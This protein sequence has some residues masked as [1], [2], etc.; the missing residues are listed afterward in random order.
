MIDTTYIKNIYPWSSSVTDDQLDFF[1]AEAYQ[2]H[3][4]ATYQDYQDQIISLYLAHKAYLEVQNNLAVG[5]ALTSIRSEKTVHGMINF[6]SGKSYWE[7]S[8][9][10]KE[11]LALKKQLGLMALGVI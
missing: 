11:Y 8:N 2:L 7:L 9:Y 4:V 5:N 6:D 3:P 1:I 10:G